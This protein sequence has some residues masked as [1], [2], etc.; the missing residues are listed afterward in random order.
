MKLETIEKKIQMHR[1]K[2]SE[3]IKLK[4]ELYPCTHE[5][6]E[7]GGGGMWHEWPEYGYYPH[8]ARCL[9]C[10]LSGELGDGSSNYTMLMNKNKQN[11][12]QAELDK[13]KIK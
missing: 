13:L 7:E 9:D 2:I 11:K 3:L 12:L 1:D 10:G 6:I 5:H 8:W 4:K